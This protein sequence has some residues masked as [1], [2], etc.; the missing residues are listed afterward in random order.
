MR[1]ALLRL[2][3]VTAIGLLVA[4]PLTAV[5]PQVAPTGDKDEL[6]IKKNVRRVIVD[7]VVTDSA[8]KPV[9]GLTKNDFSVASLRSAE[10]AAPNRSDGSSV[11]ACTPVDKRIE[12]GGFTK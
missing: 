7:V 11:A 2:A 4:L 6:V 9:H 8:R 1:L 5:E 3:L 10:T 12:S